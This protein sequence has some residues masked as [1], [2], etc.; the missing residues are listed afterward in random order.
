MKVNYTIEQSDIKRDFGQVSLEE[1]AATMYNAFHGHCECAAHPFTWDDNGDF[2]GYL[3]WDEG[4]R[5]A[6]DDVV[7]AFRLAAIAAYDTLRNTGV[8]HLR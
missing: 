7:Q 2:H 8:G 6:G 5:N 1:L 4:K 3:P